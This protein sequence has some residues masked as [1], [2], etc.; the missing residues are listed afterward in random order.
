VHIR[1]HAIENPL[2]TPQK[3]KK[4]P[5]HQPETTNTM[6]LKTNTLPID[7]LPLPQRQIVAHIRTAIAASDPIAARRQMN[8]ILEFYASHG[9]EIP[10]DLEADYAQLTILE[11][12][13]LDIP[14]VD[15]TPEKEM[16]PYQ[17]MILKM[18]ASGILESAIGDNLLATIP[19]AQHWAC[20]ILD[21]P[22]FNTYQDLHHF[23]LEAKNRHT[24]CLF[25]NKEGLDREDLWNTLRLLGHQGRLYIPEESFKDK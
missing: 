7:N 16:T 5:R 18:L 9:H 20:G 11:N 14:Q 21:L 15:E 22:T 12:P 6:T 4:N 3:P 13:D 1:W 10:E 25:M 2:P 8:E 19:F 17:E 23:L 24:P